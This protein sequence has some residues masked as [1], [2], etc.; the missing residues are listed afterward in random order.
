MS[1]KF[2]VVCYL[3]QFFGQ[4]GGEDKAGTATIFEDKP[5]GPALAFQ[6]LIKDEGTVVGTIICGDNYFNENT[7]QVLDIIIGK[8]KKLSPDVV[9]VGPAFN[10]GRYGLACAEI[11]KAVSET[12]NIPVISGMYPENPGVELGKKYMYIVQTSDSAA[13][14]RRALSQMAYLA[15][16]LAAG[17]PLDSPEKDGY[18][19]QGR[20]VTVFAEKRGSLRAVEMLLKRLKGEE[21]QTELP[22]PE[23]NRV[24]PALPIKDLSK[25]VIA[26]VC[27]GGIVPKGNPDRIESASATKYGKYPLESMFDL[28]K[29]D[30]ETIH[31]GYDPVYANE[32][33]DRVLPL[34]AMRELEALGKIG[35]LYDYF[36]STVGTGTSVANAEKFGR[37]I[38]EQL[39][40]AGVD[41]VIL[42]S[43]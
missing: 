10:A 17:I 15:K 23:F 9:V 28:R 25:A 30:Y 32:D 21:Y 14:M 19:P 4:I 34:D 22:M 27:S 33:P 6:Q 38:G 8:I 13:G 26:L 41:G 18:I 36:Y 37:E 7:K 35:R 40:A 16:K 5:V 3:N 42:T 1:S 11:G 39:K 2:Q 12:M 29:G 43:T 31:G 20:R 24:E